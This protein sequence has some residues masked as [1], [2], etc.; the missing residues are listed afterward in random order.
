MQREMRPAERHAFSSFFHIVFKAAA[1][2]TYLFASFL[3]GDY[4]ISFVLCIV[5]LSCDFW[6]VKN[7]TGRI[8]VGLRWWN[9][10]KEDGSNEWIFESVEDK[11][12]I[13]PS[14]QRLFWIAL[15]VSPAF[16]MVF[17][18]TSLLKLNFQW[19]LIVLVALCLQFANIIGYVKCAKGSMTL[20]SNFDFD[21]R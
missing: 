1:I 4:V 20:R 13:L 6:T 17:A 5:F 15:F 10:I 9:E 21:R 8:L 3:N 19:F 14:E 11:S 18:I 12:V 7:V 2:A 16:W